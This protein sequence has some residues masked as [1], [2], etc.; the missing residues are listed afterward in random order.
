M[1]GDRDLDLEFYLTLWLA[2][3]YN[4]DSDPIINSYI[5]VPLT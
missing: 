5:L 4:R 2:N 3:D 1:D